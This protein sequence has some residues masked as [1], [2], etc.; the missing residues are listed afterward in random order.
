MHATAVHSCIVA[1]ERDD[2]VGRLV[3]GRYRVEFVLARGGMSTVYHATDIRLDR[4]V[5]LKVM[6]ASLAADHSFVVRFEREAKAAAKLSHPNVVGVFDQGAYDGLVFLVMEYVPGHTLRDV[7]EE[8]GALEPARALGVVDQVLM[9]LAAAHEAGFV[10][11]DIKPEN[12][13]ITRDGMVKVADFGLA[14]ALTGEVGTGTVSGQNVFMG[15]V[16]Y[17]APEQVSPGTA[18]ARSDIYSTGVLLFELLTGE[19]P[20]TAATP[21]AVAL[22]HVNEDVPPPSSLVPTTPE[23][24]DD[25]VLTATAR[26]PEARFQSA[27]EFEQALAEAQD[28][29]MTDYV[30]A[31]DAPPPPPPPP[32]PPVTQVPTPPTPSDDTSGT[33]ATSSSAAGVSGSA[34]AA[35]AQVPVPGPDSRTAV[36]TTGA[37]EAPTS[38]VPSPPDAWDSTPAPPPVPV[39][40]IPA[41]PGDA[42]T[43]TRA[44]T[45]HAA[46][47]THAGQSSHAAHAAQASHHSQVVVP[48]RREAT[49]VMPR[50]DAHDPLVYTEVPPV[51]PNPTPLTTGGPP[52]NPR[53][54]K[55][56]RRGGRR[57]I[58]I[59]IALL[60]LL[61]GV[62][63]WFLG[64][65]H[66]VAV[67]DVAGQSVNEAS[68]TLA[69]AELSLDQSTT[70]A[71]DSVP[72]GDIIRTDPGAG[73][74]AR[75]GSTVKAIVS[76]GPAV[77][78]IPDVAGTSV[79]E[80]TKKLRDA[81][82]DVAGTQAVYDG[83][84]PR[85][86]VI[87]TRP[88]S[89]TPATTGAQVTLLVSR[90]GEPLDLPD[91]AG[92]S[93]AEAK[94]TLTD[95]GLV[96]SVTEKTAPAGSTNAEVLGTDPVAGTTVQPGDSVVLFV[97]KPQTTVT[98]PDVTGLSQ[99]EAV[100][101]LQAA[102]LS[103][104]SKN[105]LTIVVLDRV[106]SQDPAAG[107]VVPRGSTVTLTIV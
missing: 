91:V 40:P 18:D 85:D 24:L 63:A 36:V 21:I 14:R 11:R 10:H 44:T 88:A 28:Q 8:Y 6:D 23:Y 67:P 73:H 103:P 39:G 93:S 54:V 12:V 81:K 34:A 96:V 30:E 95:A 25:L 56:S 72:Q 29:V 22:K 70:E 45:A 47:S 66:Y 51:N 4:T 15:T 98:V 69:V 105:Q 83:R 90:G 26:P 58:I 35:T 16:A 79:D 49:Q 89:G 9:A 46:Q 76:T 20:F 53:G 106:Y 82:F 97:S 13:L 61:V 75:T 55:G 86:Q 41:G 3:D 65:R 107:T 17:I 50:P 37:A 64:S 77:V 1:A 68:R 84:V 94:R 104:A 27:W 101:R 42:A 5:A 60:A 71:S 62:G 38:V 92:M 43:G 19:V 100:A 33:R 80:A 99:Q 87:G 2:I 48:A 31:E 52:T 7:I 57:R 32:S 59:V 74:R 78:S 102:G